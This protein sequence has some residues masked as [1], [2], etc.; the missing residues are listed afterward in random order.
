MQLNRQLATE[1]VCL[2]VCVCPPSCQPHALLG[3]DF[4]ID[5]LVCS[6]CRVC[7]ILLLTCQSITRLAKRLQLN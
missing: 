2:V 4:L 1:C 7:L 3:N 5:C 6:V